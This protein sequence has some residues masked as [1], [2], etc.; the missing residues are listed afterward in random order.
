MS[1]PY[2]QDDYVTIYHGDCRGILPELAANSVDLV[3]TDPP[4]GMGYQSNMRYE[5]Y[6]TIIDDDRFPRKLLNDL[7]YDC[8][9]LLRRDTAI[10]L[11][12]QF[13]IYPRL[14]PI[15][16][17][18]FEFKNLLVWAKNHQSAG[19]LK[20]DYGRQYENIL[21]AVKGGFKI[22]GAR[23]SNIL[24]YAIVDGT[25]SLHPTQKPE[26]LI[27]HLIIKSTDA[28][29]L[30]VDPFLGSGT[31][32]CC[33]KKHSR[34]CIGIELKEEYCE[35]A[36]NRCRQMS[37]DLSSPTIIKDGSPEPMFYQFLMY[38]DSGKIQ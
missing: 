25:V 15:V 28:G 7:M 24:R 29:M 13:H 36:A 38:G 26:G 6:D 35:V 33:A 27:E 17:D 34:R 20:G 31:T 30:V 3:L 12:T 32:A 11:F 5:K 23:P 1:E 2:Y 4:Y 8:Y 22:R 14:L 19:D 21:F 18:V 16:A 10:Y 37:M 9:R